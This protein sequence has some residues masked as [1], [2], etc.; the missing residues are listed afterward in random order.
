MEIKKRV[1]FRLFQAGKAI[2]RFNGLAKQP[3]FCLSIN[4]LNSILTAPGNLVF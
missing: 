4:C 2:G 3:T 1:L